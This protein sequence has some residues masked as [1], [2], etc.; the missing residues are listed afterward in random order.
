MFL[1]AT[2]C[3]E[4]RLDIIDYFGGKGNYGFTFY[5]PAAYQRH[6]AAGRRLRAVHSLSNTQIG[7]SLSVQGDVAQGWELIEEVRREIA[8]LQKALERIEARL[9]RLR[10]SASVPLQAYSEYWERFYRPASDVLADQIV[11]SG[12]FEY[13]P[14]ISVVLPTRN[15]VTRLLDRAIGSVR[16]QSYDVWEL[17]IADDAS[18]LGEEL[19]ILWRR[20]S[21]ADPRIRLV[22]GTIPEGLA[23]ITTRGITAARGEYV[24]F[25]GQDGELAH[26]ALFHIASELQRERY[27]LL[28]S[29]ED[30]V[31]ENEFRSITHRAPVLKP[32]FDPE[33][34]LAENYFGHLVV[35][36]SDVLAAVNG[37]RD[38]LDGATEYE[39]SL[40]IAAFLPAQ[41]IR[42]VVR[43]LYHRHTV[44]PAASAATERITQDIVSTAQKHAQ[45]GGIDVEIE[46]H[47]DPI[48]VPR[49]FAT[50][51]RWRIPTLP[52]GI[53]IVVPTRDRLDLLQPCVDSV[54]ESR[55]A[56]PGPFEIL[57]IDNDLVESS[58][59]GYLA[60][61]VGR[62]ETRVLPFGGVF[63]WSAM[64]NFAAQRARGE[65][66]IFVNNDVVVLTKDW[67][68]E[69][70]ANA[71]RPEIGAVGARLLYA[72]GR[73]QH[74]GVL[75]GVQ[76]VAGHD[77]IGEPG[78]GG[79]YLGRIHLQRQAAAVT[80][81]CLA[82]RRRLFEEIGGFDELDLKVS[83]SDVD[84]CLR[85]R[86]RGYRIVYNPFAVLYHFESRSR[87]RNLSE[88]QQEREQAEGTTLLARWGQ[89][90]DADPFYNPHFER[91][92]RAFER[93]RPPRG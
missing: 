9:P 24:A 23:E 69:L 79:G 67:C 89:L 5:I 65:V 90:I 26:D 50:R 56:Y 84:Y 4:P 75:L 51:V 71:I 92:A 87:G 53:S 8:G 68:R 17:I 61:L 11:A 21:A 86:H 43:V 66:L 59:R 39:L 22:E 41:Q 6:F 44:P 78:N 62:P 32:D 38:A 77:L 35:V 19:R 3:A 82:T 30:W 70:A 47:A 49:P 74:A 40:R 57:V 88:A 15:S 54:L 12:A 31:E 2:G 64:C 48:G 83:F 7:D 58:A 25:L 91:F 1:G 45:R 33:L 76:G 34:L 93:L 16:A 81:A 28:Y 85:I 73:I 52:P 63:N 42:H 29:D 72:D 46:A 60:G 36:R 55:E 14:L 80:G 37:V 18:T 13:R 10:R 27:G 20:H